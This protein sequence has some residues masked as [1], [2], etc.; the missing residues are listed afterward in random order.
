MVQILYLC[1]IADNDIGV[2]GDTDADYDDVDV[3]D[4][5]IF[6]VGFVV[7]FDSSSDWLLVMFKQIRCDIV[8][9]KGDRKR[10]ETAMLDK[11][12]N[13]SAVID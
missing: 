9:F 1:C 7:T 5:I 4:G 8:N 11:G 12:M 2:T 10:K 3:D 6:T 13:V